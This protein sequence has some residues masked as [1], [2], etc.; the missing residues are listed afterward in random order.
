MRKGNAFLL[1]R[2]YSRCARD[3][4]I[5]QRIKRSLTGFSGGIC[6]TGSTPQQAG[7]SRDQRARITVRDAVIDFMRRVGMTSVFAN[8]GSTELPMFRNFPADFRYVLGLQEAVVV[9]MADGY[10]QATGNASLVNLHSAAGVGNAMGNIFTAFR[11]QSPIVVTAGQQARSILPFDP[12]LAST[13]AT[14]LPKPYVK[15]S[16]EP[17]RAADVPLAIARAYHIAMQEPRGPVFVSIP[18]DDWDQPAD[19]VPASD[20]STVTRPDPVML[21]RMGDALDQ[22]ERPAFVVGGG[23]ARAGEVDEVVRLAERHQARVFV[24]PC[25]DAAAFLRI[26]GCSPVSFPPCARRSSRYWTAMISSACSVLPRSLTTWKATV[27]TSPRARN[28][29]SLST[30]PVWPPGPRPARL[31]RK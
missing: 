27:R 26:I 10:A 25:R 30:T 12:F 11:N 5:M 6:M 23:V 4:I 31:D 1:K 15:W 14:E 7:S 28:Y 20:V 2:Q 21:V 22:C 17:A 9:G 8:P 13:Q 3:W 29:S 16:I 19:Y 24:R 18:A